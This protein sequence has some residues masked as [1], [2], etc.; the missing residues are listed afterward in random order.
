MNC[1]KCE[2]VLP[3]DTKRKI[4]NDCKKKMGRRDTLFVVGFLIALGL[5]GA[6][7]SNNDPRTVARSTPTPTATVDL[8]AQLL[9]AQQK[10]ANLYERNLT[11]LGWRVNVLVPE[12][13]VLELRTSVL[14]PKEIS[15]TILND[16]KAVRNFNLVQFRTLRVRAEDSIL[17]AKFDYVIPIK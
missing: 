10:F 2:A 14:S 7:I 11:E 17:A 3:A 16:D 4:C 1:Y 15:S 5:L 12:L 6:F 8:N 9:D 13:G